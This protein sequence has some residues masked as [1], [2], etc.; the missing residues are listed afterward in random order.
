MQWNN[1]TH[2]S[3]SPPPAADVLRLT[4]AN[5]ELILIGSRSYNAIC[6][7]CVCAIC[8]GIIVSALALEHWYSI[9]FFYRS[10]FKPI[11]LL[12]LMSL[13]ALNIVFYQRLVPVAVTHRRRIFR[14]YSTT[15]IDWKRGESIRK[16]INEWLLR[17]HQAPQ[18][19]H[20]SR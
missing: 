2:T 13:S 7:H 17:L 15:D 12:L 9:G 10:H 14:K 11:A 3:G 6:M 1:S 5:V 20:N 16:Y 18:L 8:N 4:N 19:L